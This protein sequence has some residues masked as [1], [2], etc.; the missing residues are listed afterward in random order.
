MAAQIDHVVVLMLENRSCDNML[1]RLYPDDPRFNGLTLNERNVYYGQTYGVWSGTGMGPEIACL[2]KPDPGE[3]FV[4]MNQQLFGALPPNLVPPAA[5]PDM[6]GFAANYA[7]QKPSKDGPFLA[8]NAMHYFDP[9]QVPIL[10]ALARSFG[11]CDPWH[12]SAPCQTWPNRFFA[13]TGT[14]LGYVENRK[15]PIPFPAPSIFRQL[16]AH[17]QSWRVYFHDMPQAA[18]L[19]D[20]W[21]YA[22]FH[23]KGFEHFL[24]D[25][26][27]GSLPS[28]SFIEP[29]YFSDLFL[30]RI[31]N[32]EHPPHNVVYG[33]QLIAQV[34][35][36][37][38]ASPCW[39]RTLLIITYDEHG[40][41]YDH[42]PPPAAVSPDGIANNPTDFT[43]TRYGVRVP[44][45]IVS[46]YVAP[47]SII[48]P[49]PD[50]AGGEPVP[51]DHT[52]IIATLRELF[53]K[54]APALTKR[55]AQAPHLLGALSLAVPSNEGPES[56]DAGYA[57]PH[58]T[59]VQD[60][61]VA[62]TN[63]MQDA[64]SAAAT[65]LPLSPPVSEADVPEAA[66]LPINPYATVATAQANAADRTR[67]FLGA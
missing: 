39:P 61:A 51:F 30:N 27:T 53:L 29:R 1:G 6:S 57:T 4:D 65:L 50:P 63:G 44:A 48:K 32:D 23:F 33:E 13:H 64:L 25:A 43:F 37:V 36:A 58:Y 49:P 47:G 15:F 26:H 66:S 34:Y 20:I 31:P 3:D 28:Y 46:P 16:Q 8:T 40:G 35:N 10:S 67:M 42:V 24:A 14:C 62:A 38:R 60:R 12:A 17:G 9:S 5:V 54:G 52:S 18:L 2:P 59:E 19:R 7:T 22:L 21:L 41:C 45:L 56:L 11:V 55:D